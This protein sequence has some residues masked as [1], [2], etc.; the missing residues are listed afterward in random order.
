MERGGEKGESEIRS[1]CVTSK[2]FS[3]KIII[4]LHCHSLKKT[5]NQ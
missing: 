5:H 3:G 4:N 1:Y 2:S